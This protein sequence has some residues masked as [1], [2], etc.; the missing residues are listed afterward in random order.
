MPPRSYDDKH[1]GSSE[2]GGASGP[3]GVHHKPVDALSASEKLRLGYLT[4]TED[5]EAPV[6]RHAWEGTD[7]DFW[8]EQERLYPKP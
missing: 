7:P 3:A 2:F 6:N 4:G 8:E 5:T 1:Q